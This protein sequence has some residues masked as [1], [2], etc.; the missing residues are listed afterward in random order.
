MPPPHPHS[1][2]WHH[3]HHPP[4]SPSPYSA[5]PCPA[6]RSL[7][8]DGRG[9]AVVRSA[10]ELEGAVA[11]LGGYEKGLYAEKWVPFVCELAVRGSS[12]GRAGGRA[13]V[14]GEVGVGALGAHAFRALVCVRAFWALRLQ[15][16]FGCC[17]PAALMLQ[18]AQLPAL[19]LLCR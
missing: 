2:H 1:T 19:C 5:L 9:N 6:R 17:L 12:G 8:Y 3:H 15:Q 7:A 13:H 16:L 11:S 18:C 14:C 4:H 10:E